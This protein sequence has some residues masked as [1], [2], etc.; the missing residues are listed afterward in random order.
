MA[1][2]IGTVC[3]VRESEQS[4][5]TVFWSQTYTEWEQVYLTR[6]MVGMSPNPHLALD[7][8]GYNQKQ[9]PSLA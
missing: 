3:D 2:C 8:K 7:E 5:G 4:L 6:T 1:F 9:Q